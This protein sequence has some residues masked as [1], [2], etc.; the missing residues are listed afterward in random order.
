MKLPVVN[1]AKIFA[2]KVLAPVL[3]AAYPILALWAYNFDR[4]RPTEVVYPLFLSLSGSL[5]LFLILRLILRDALKSSLLSCVMILLFFSYGHVFSLINNLPGIGPTL[6]HQRYLMLTWLILFATSLVLIIKYGKNANNLH[7][8]INYTALILVGLVCIQ[9]LF[10]EYSQTQ[11]RVNNRLTKLEDKNAFDPSRIENKNNLPDVYLIVLD[12]YAREDVLERELNFDNKPFIKNL[13]D[14]GFVVPNCTMTNYPYTAQIMPAELNMNY[15]DA[16]YPYDST[17]T[18]ID[19][20]I[21]IDDIRHSLVRKNLTD[22][23]YK[24]ISFESNPQWVEIPDADIFH[25]SNTPGQFY[26]RIFD[27]TEYHQILSDST[28]LSSLHDAEGV[29]P[30]LHDVR[31]KFEDFVASINTNLKFAVE[32]PNRKKYNML[33]DYLDYMETVTSIPG[34]KF[35]YLH[36]MAPHSPQVLGP[37]GEFVPGVRIPGYSYAVTYV[38]KRI[39]G[40]ISKIINQSKV[41]PVIILQGDH[42]FSDDEKSRMYNLN[43]Y[44]L[45][46]AGK[47]LLYPTITPVNTFRVIFNAYFDGKY[48]LLKDTGYWFQGALFNFKKAPVSCVP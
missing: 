25:S 5:L 21:A 38:N 28:L 6:A 35:V 1:Y 13:T 23:G 10:A 46:G 3:F 24:T 18:R 7:R 32:D 45:P 36:L 44:Y 41:P 37:N 29:I 34:H 9:L 20:N 33:I 47:K 30:G 17:M 4:M 15:L 11:A 19:Y 26:F 42:G 48:P 14:L 43:A 16:F 2:S 22:L 40:I 12:S 8:I 27:K 39:L 31:S